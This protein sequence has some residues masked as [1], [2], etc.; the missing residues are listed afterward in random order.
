MCYGRAPTFL[1]MTGYEQV[2]SVVAGL[3]GDHEAAHRVELVLPDT[4]VSAAPGVRRSRR[5]GRRGSCGRRNL[6]W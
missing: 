6:L 5:P 3:A 1:A 4:G 2:R